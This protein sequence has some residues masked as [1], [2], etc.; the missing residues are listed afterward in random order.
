MKKK[1]YVV[2]LLNASNEC[3][4]SKVVTT[5]SSFEAVASVFMVVSI[6]V[7]SDVYSNFKDSEFIV[8]VRP[9]VGSDS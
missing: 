1:K 7:G 9:Y 2:S 6:A 4:F 5:P 8:S 3:V